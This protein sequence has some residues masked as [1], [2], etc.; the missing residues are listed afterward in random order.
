MIYKPVCT[1]D[2]TGKRKTYGND[3][4]AKAAGAT[5]IRSGRCLR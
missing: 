1:I 4:Q 3:C 5:V 2:S